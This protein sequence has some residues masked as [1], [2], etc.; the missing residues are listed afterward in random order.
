MRTQLEQ[1][2]SPIKVVEI[3]PPSVETDL[4]R[5]RQNPDDNKKSS[6]NKMTLSMDEFMDEV[7]EG[8]KKNSDVITAGPGHKVVDAW[9]EY[10]LCRAE[11]EG[12]EV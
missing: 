6:G 1:A 5:E 9:N 10:G 12:A 2:K 8:W 4:H 3:A 7:E 11:E